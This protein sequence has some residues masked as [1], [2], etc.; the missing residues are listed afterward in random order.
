MRR[1]AVQ[2]IP[3]DCRAIVIAKPE[4]IDIR[5]AEG[6]S[7]RVERIIPSYEDRINI[8]DGNLELHLREGRRG[9]ETRRR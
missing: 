2:R 4:R 7:G 9:T 3:A 8:N 5:R 1:E 6:Q